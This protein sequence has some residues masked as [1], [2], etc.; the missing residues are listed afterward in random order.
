MTYP[1]EVLS[2]HFSKRGLCARLPTHT[3]SLRRERIAA[4]HRRPAHGGWFGHRTRPVEFSRDGKRM[5]NIPGS[6]RSGNL[7]FRVNSVWS[8]NCWK[9]MLAFDP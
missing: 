2:P 9:G 3:R 7:G 5:G 4:T 8:P 6:Y 1:V